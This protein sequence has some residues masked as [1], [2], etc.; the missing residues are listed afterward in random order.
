MPIEETAKICR[1]TVRIFT[2]AVD[3]QWL[4]KQSNLPCSDQQKHCQRNGKGAIVLRGQPTCKEH[5]EQKIARGKNT[6]ISKRPHSSASTDRQ[7]LAR[8]RK[9][10]GGIPWQQIIRLLSEM[11]GEHTYTLWMAC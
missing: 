3:Q 11:R 4:T 1:Q 2:S 7:A 10:S 9:T 8:F 5:L 6:L